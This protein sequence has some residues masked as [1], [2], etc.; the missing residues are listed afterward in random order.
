MQE[1]T[2][3]LLSADG[4]RPLEW[5][6][7][8]PDGRV[9]A[10]GLGPPPRGSAWTGLL[11]APA[12]SVRW[13]QAPQRGRD[14]WRAAA[15][16]ALEDQ[17]ADELE[18]LHIALPERFEAGPV[19]VAVVRRDWFAQWLDELHAQD[20]KP[21]RVLPIAA[22]VGAEALLTIEELSTLKQSG[23]GCTMEHELLAVTGAGAALEAVEDPLAYLAGQLRTQAA[24]ELLSGPFLPAGAA[25]GGE[26]TVWR[27]AALL[28]VVALL[29]ELGQ[30]ALV[31]RRL[32]AEEARLE[33][34]S[35]QILVQTLG[36]GTPRIPGSE[37]LQMQN[38]L[39]RRT[40]TGAGS[41]GVLG[42]LAAIGPILASEGRVKLKGLEFRD[43]R[44]ELLLEGGD[45]RSF[46]VL[47]ERF[48]SVPGLKTEVGDLNYGKATVTGRIRIEGGT[49]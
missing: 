22:L 28:L 7:T 6:T 29:A 35:A 46:D 49:P 41:G 40:G 14:K 12:L 33:A 45:V 11:A 37:R 38:E 20:L 42:L 23:V 8:G 44:L 17:V 13:L 16:F 26:R 15:R 47:R 31:V 36:P 5:L 1:R 2:L 43:Q 48:A 39:D 9:R 27:W 34:E 3:V 10:R 18:Q 4:S 30:R 19:P 21:A 25:G 24:P 32:A